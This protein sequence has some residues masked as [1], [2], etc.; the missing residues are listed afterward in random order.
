MKFNTVAR[1]RFSLYERETLKFVKITGVVGHCASSGILKTRKHIFSESYSMVLK[2]LPFALCT[3]PCQY[4]LFKYR[5]DLLC[6]ARTD[7]GLVYSA[8]ERMF[9]NMLPLVRE[10][11]M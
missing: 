4:R 8:K 3:S 10:D 2:I 6:K 9:S 1:R 11:V 5:H 7:R